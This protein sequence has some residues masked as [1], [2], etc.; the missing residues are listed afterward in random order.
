MTSTINNLEVKN[1]NGVIF[2]I[3]NSFGKRTECLAQVMAIEK[4]IYTFIETA[5]A[6]AQQD[7]AY[8]DAPIH[9]TFFSKE[10]AEKAAFN[11]VVE[12]VANIENDFAAGYPAPS[13]Q[14]TIAIE[15]NAIVMR[16]ANQY[17]QVA[18]CYEV[19]GGYTFICSEQDHANAAAGIYNNG[20]YSTKNGALNAALRFVEKMYNKLQDMFETG[21]IAYRS[22]AAQ[23][24]LMQQA[25]AVSILIIK[26]QYIDITFARCETDY[27]ITILTFIGNTALLEAA[28]AVTAA[29]I[30]AWRYEK[31][32]FGW[33]VR[34]YT[35]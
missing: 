27:C 22:K 12:M 26:G 19:E 13:E 28:Q 8:S 3:D 11:F 30:K 15:K 35:F 7:A 16:S 24:Q 21:Y 32:P 17:G 31:C 9:G 6:A 4:G 14:P 29:G 2:I 23:M 33:K 1:N 25:E 18:V 20:F 5:N 10:E 34:V